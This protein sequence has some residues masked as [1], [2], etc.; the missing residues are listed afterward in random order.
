MPDMAAIKFKQCPYVRKHFFF[1]QQQTLEFQSVFYRVQVNIRTDKLSYVLNLAPVTLFVPVQ[2]IFN[3]T[4]HNI[5]IS[6]DRKS[7]V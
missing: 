4:R 6:L 1:F 5:G 2:N 3:L 7:V